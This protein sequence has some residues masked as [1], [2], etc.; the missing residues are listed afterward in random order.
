[1]GQTTYRD[2]W[3][4]VR[5]IQT[6]VRD[7]ALNPGQPTGNGKVAPP[8]TM[9]TAPRSFG[10]SGLR[11]PP[12]AL[13]LEPGHRPTEA[14]VSRKNGTLAPE[15]RKALLADMGKVHGMVERQQYDEAKKLAENVAARCYR[16]GVSSAHVSWALAVIADYQGDAEGAFKNVM[17]AV[18]MDPLEPNIVRSFDIITDRLRA[19]LLDPERDVAEEFTARLHAMLVQAGKADDL[20]H[21]AMARH[22]AATGKD[23]EAMKLLDAVTTLFP[24]CRDAWVAKASVAKK[25]G[26]TD[27]ALAAE[28]AAS[29]CDGNAAPMFAIS[30]RAEA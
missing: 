18:Q 19:A 24:S 23:G 28:M 9:T 17:E 6:R 20:A 22:L 4:N 8:R 5:V 30:G 2:I 3:Y 27:D 14:L 15:A 21:V 7:A 29:S 12:E 10:S 13:D 25:L 16:A 1:M 11:L 26:L